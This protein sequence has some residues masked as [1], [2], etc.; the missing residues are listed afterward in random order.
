MHDFMNRLTQT[1]ERLGLT[2]TELGK[3]CGM[4]PTQISRYEMGRA[5]P[6]RAAL[7]RLADALK[8]EPGWLLNGGG[9]TPNLD[10]EVEQ[11]AEGGSVVSFVA[12][13]PTMTKLDQMAHEAGMSPDEFLRK[14]VMDG[15]RK[16]ID[17]VEPD[18]G[19]AYVELRRRVD[20]IEAQLQPKVPLMAKV[21]G[22]EVDTG[23]MVSPRKPMPAE[24]MRE[25][26]NPMLATPRMLEALKDQS[27]VMIRGF[28]PAA[29][30]YDE[31]ERQPSTTGPQPSP[32]ARK[33]V[34]KK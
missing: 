10:V 28:D 9:S 20:A 17:A 21:R 24:T 8:V 19:D 14:I 5:V 33:R 18:T 23:L 29:V 31:V 1:R 7:R 25:G 26:K 32:N 34:V 6:R 27:S 4:A 12:D 22:K 2:Q 15:V 3:L 13:E 11:L 16:V 30:E